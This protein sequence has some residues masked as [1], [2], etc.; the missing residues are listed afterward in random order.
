MKGDNEL[1]NA[2]EPILKARK[3]ANE[4]RMLSRTQDAADEGRRLAAEERRVAAEERKVSL[5]EKK[6]AMEERTRL[7]K[8]EKYLF[9]IMDASSLEEKQ[10]EYVNL[11]LE[12]VLGK[13][14]AWEAWELP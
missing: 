11:A 2:M 10:K 6:L 14:E 4:V 12:E 1:K 9:F 3:E 13:N 8:W 7:L 5:E